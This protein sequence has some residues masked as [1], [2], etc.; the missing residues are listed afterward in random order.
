MLNE[1][2]SIVDNT[3]NITIKVLEDIKSQ[4]NLTNQM[5]SEINS[6]NDSF[7]TIKQT[8]FQHIEDARAVDQ[9]LAFGISGINENTK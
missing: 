5:V 9:Q 4:H 2:N 7:A 6:T 3:K 1:M 8:L